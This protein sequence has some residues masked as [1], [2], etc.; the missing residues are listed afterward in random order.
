MK[1]NTH[2][3]QRSIISMIVKFENNIKNNIMIT[4][5]MDVIKTQQCS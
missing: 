5:E 1:R 3:T 2:T 4:H